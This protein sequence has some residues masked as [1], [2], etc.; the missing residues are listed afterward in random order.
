MS[1]A[2]VGCWLDTGQ[3][4]L[5]IMGTYMTMEGAG[6]EELKRRSGGT[7]PTADEAG[8]EASAAAWEVTIALGLALHGRIQSE[9]SSS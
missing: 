9:R 6:R 3:A 2:T 7:D 4:Y 8:E 5:A 1:S